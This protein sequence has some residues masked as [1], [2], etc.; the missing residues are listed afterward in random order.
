MSSVGV[1][2]A[3]NVVAMRILARTL[4]RLLGTQNMA[5]GEC[6]ANANNEPWAN[7]TTQSKIV[8]HKERESKLVYGGPIIAPTPHM[9]ATTA[10]HDP[11]LPLHP[12]TTLPPTPHVTRA[13]LPV[14]QAEFWESRVPAA[15][16]W[17]AKARKRI[18]YIR[19]QKA[20]F[21]E[22]QIL[23]R[24]TLGNR[25]QKAESEHLQATNSASV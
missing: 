22:P 18:P 21:G 14:T 1:L 15:N 12:T 13:G 5:S 11:P 24:P 9:D 10:D 19:F 8:C 3:V 25:I 20:E 16:F 17:E 4:P 2:N 23:E 6:H 7:A